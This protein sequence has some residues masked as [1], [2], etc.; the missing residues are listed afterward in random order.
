MEDRVRYAGILRNRLV[1]EV[2][3]ALLVYRHVLQQR[4]AADGVPDVGLVLLREVDN[5]GVAAALEVEYAVVVP[6]VLVVADQLA[7]R[8]GRKRGLAGSRQTEED[9]RLA[10][11]VGVGRAV[12]RSHALERKQVVHVGEHALLHLAA[13]P[14]VDDDLHLLGEVEDDGRLRVQTE[15]LVVLDLGLRCVEHDEIGLAVILQFGV[16][17]TD[18]HVLNEVRLPSHLHDEADLQTRVLVGAA[19]SIDD[20]KLLARQ[21]LRSDLLQLFPSRLGYGLVVV[22][23]LVGSP[24]DRIFRGLVHYEELV[25]GRTAGV[26]AGHHVHGAHFGLLTL[27]EAAEAL[28]GLLAEEFVVRRIVHDLGHTRDPVL[29]QIHFV[30]SNRY[31]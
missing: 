22:L 4:V 12:H 20:V 31:F 9:S 8:V 17:R 24:P 29:F 1:G 19:E 18:E 10:F 14:R 3:L 11:G 16:G 7:L 27:F 28:L 25:F 5:L 6:A 23:I 2:D 13:V 21:L 15:F 26:N 30:H